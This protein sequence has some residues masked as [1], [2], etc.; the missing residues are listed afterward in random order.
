VNVGMCV[1]VIVCMCECLSVGVSGLCWSVCKCEYV[2]VY[3]CECVNTNVCECECV[4]E[5]L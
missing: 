2:S 1:S 4:R 5:F 3:E